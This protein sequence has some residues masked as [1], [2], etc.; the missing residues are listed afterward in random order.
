MVRAAREAD[1]SG[2]GKVVDR[3]LTRGFEWAELG[4]RLAVDR[5]DDAFAAARSA[6]DRGDIVAKAANSNALHIRRVS[7][8]VARVYTLRIGE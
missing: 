3:W 8:S 2:G 4:D 6:H 1:E 7:G 5:D